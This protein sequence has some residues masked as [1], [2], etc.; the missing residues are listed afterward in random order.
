MEPVAAERTIIHESYFSSTFFLGVSLNGDCWKTTTNAATGDFKHTCLD[1]NATGQPDCVAVVRF[2][3]GLK[4]K[5]TFFCVA[6]PAIAGYIERV[7]PA[8][9][10]IGWSTEE[11]IP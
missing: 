8:V 5:Y 1:T 2:T 4:I 11:E 7:G 10:V 9:N 3:T 6:N